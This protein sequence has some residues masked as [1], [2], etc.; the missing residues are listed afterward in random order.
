MGRDVVERRSR[1]GAFVGSSATSGGHRS[2]D[3]RLLAVDLGGTHLRCAIVSPEGAVSGHQRIDTPTTSSD[4]GPV[5]EFI[6]SAAAE[7]DASTVV[8]GLP[9]RIDYERGCLDRAPNLPA[10]WVRALDENDLSEAVGV[11]VSVANDADLAAVGEAWLGAGRAWSD[12]VYLTVSTGVGAG[13]VLGDQ[14]VHGRRSL[15]EIGQSLVDE[16]S[17]RIGADAT[18]IE[19]VASGAALG[20]RAAGAGL[21]ARGPE[22][23]SAIRAGDA[24]MAGVWED[25]VR[26]VGLAVVNLTWIFTPQAVVVGGGLGLVGELLLAPIRE[27]VGRLGPPLLPEP[28]AVVPAALGDDAGLIGGAAWSRAFRPEAAGRSISP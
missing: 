24:R 22:I 27:L 25:Q 14:L 7:A 16:A 3:E 5:V 4:A 26:A 1:T 20:R 18:S 8:I 21:V 15:A 23:I 6:R 19:D 12:V 28:I 10:G 11:P 9:G 13:V 2:G 17:L